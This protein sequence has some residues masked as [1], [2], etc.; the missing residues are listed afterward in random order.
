MF[1]QHKIGRWNIGQQKDIFQYN[2]ETYNRERQ[3]TLN[4]NEDLIMMPG[5]YD[6]EPLDIY[7]LERIDEYN[8]GDDYN[9]DTYDFSELNED[10][11]DGDYY[12]EDRDEDD[13]PE[14]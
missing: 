5:E 14:D 4:Q 12:P 10:Y 6:R 3:E 1:Q 2:P 8:P 7:D 13:F 11:M 9:R